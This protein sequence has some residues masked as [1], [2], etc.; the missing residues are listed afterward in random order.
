MPE[1]PKLARMHTAEHLLSAV[2]RKFYNAPRNLELH[3]GE[4]KTKCDYDLPQPL[5]DADVE[6]IQQL[7]NEEIAKNHA[8]SF[9]YIKRSEAQQFD[10]WKVPADMYDLRIVRIGDFDAQPCSGSHVRSTSEI[11]EFVIASLE[12]R[13]NGRTRIR[14]RV[15]SQPLQ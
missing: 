9:A 2:M 1:T 4:K 13:E 7:V 15:T 11:G 10:L 8:V 3:L 6:K 12:K 5:A 14:F